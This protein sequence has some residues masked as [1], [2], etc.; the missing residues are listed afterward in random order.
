MGL[1]EVNVT[2]VL[3]VVV[4]SGMLILDKNVSFV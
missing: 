2:H 1:Q 3:G 4:M